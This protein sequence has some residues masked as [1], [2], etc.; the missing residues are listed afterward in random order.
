MKYMCLECTRI[1]AARFLASSCCHPR[2]ADI[3][4]DRVR[5]CRLDGEACADDCVDC[6]G[7]GF[8]LWNLA[9]AFTLIRKRS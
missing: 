5:P 8:K 3:Q 1:Y 4:D 6:L 7:T 2:V 9:D